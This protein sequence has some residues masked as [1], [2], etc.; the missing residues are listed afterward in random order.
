MKTINETKLNHEVYGL[1]VMT[2]FNCK[3]EVVNVGDFIGNSYHWVDGCSSGDAIDGT[4]AIF[5]DVDGFDGEVINF[6]AAVKLAEQYKHDDEQVVIVGG[7][8]S[9]D[10]VF[11]DT[12]EIVIKNAEVLE[13]L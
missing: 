1:R 4:C 6:D 13:I 11:N 10:E 5:L 12:N 2:R 9:I 8:L 7:D 3:H